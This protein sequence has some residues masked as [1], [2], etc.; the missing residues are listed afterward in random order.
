M[1]A[2]DAWTGAGNCR[3]AAAPQAS[4]AGHA[5]PPHPAQPSP[6]QAQPRGLGGPAFVISSAKA[7]GNL[8]AIAQLI[9]P[10]AAWR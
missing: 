4:G 6:V 2:C 5:Y 8:P 10:Q 1:P 9:A 7:S 3:K